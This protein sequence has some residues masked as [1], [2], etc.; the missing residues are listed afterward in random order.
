MVGHDSLEN[1]FKTNFAMMQ[2]H[3]YNLSDLENMLPWERVVYTDLLKQLIKE[4]EDRMKEQ[5]NLQ[6]V[7][8]Q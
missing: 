5:R 2:H 4:E 7:R 3:K 6:R 8:R 1:Y